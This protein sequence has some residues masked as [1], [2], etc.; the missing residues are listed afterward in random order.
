MGDEGDERVQAGELLGASC[1]TGTSQGRQR[2]ADDVRETLPR[3]P[4]C[5][6]HAVAHP[7]P[8]NR[9]TP[10]EGRT[11]QG[12]ATRPASAATSVGEALGRCHSRGGGEQAQGPNRATVRVNATGDGEHGLLATP[13][14]SGQLLA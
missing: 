6:R 5:P 8:G 14:D 12:A 4:P 1:S 2:D 7:R 9:E 13:T 3:L 10:R 11:D